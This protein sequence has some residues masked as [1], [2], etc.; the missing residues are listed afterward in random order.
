MSAV[1]LNEL[2][3]YA[4]DVASQ[5]LLG[6]KGALALCVL[7]GASGERTVLEVDTGDGRTNMVT[8]AALRQLMR[9]RGTVVYIWTSEA[10]EVLDE[11]DEP[12]AVLPSDH[13]KR[14]EVVIAVASNGFGSLAR[15]WAI[16]RDYKG[17]VAA[18]EKLDEMRGGA[19]GPLANLLGARA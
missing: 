11:D 13:S 9:D 10:W 5:Q 16:R 12:D 1:D 19:F 2:L 3:E 4:S 7:V 18:L 6:K 17:S 15:S 8:Y 14:Q